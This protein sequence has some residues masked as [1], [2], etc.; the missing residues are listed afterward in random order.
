MP[1]V[2][3]LP[4]VICREVPKVSLCHEL[5][6]QVRGGICPLEDLEIQGVFVHLITL[7]R[8]QT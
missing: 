3:W 6:L 5:L 8:R 1:K 7:W 2:L 4:A